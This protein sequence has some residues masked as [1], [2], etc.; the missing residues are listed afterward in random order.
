M[1]PNTGGRINCMHTGRP[2]TG[3]MSGVHNT[4]RS[5]ELS[6]AESTKR[7]CMIGVLTPR[8]NGDCIR[9]S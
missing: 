5:Q 4:R 6:T 2:K 1:G 3:N 9:S 8:M 7:D